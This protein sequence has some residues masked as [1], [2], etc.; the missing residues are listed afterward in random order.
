MAR[1]GISNGHCKPIP[2]LEKQRK[3]KL[4]F[5]YKLGNMDM[6]DWSQS[7]SSIA[8]LMA[9]KTLHFPLF[10][11]WKMVK[12]SSELNP[13]SLFCEKIIRAQ[14]PIS[15]LQNEGKKTKI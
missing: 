9:M 8:C 3:H 1:K 12:N 10:A 5:L 7:H 13:L 11:Q 2:N 15:H 6:V 14:F 4:K